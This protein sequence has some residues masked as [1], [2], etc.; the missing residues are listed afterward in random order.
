MEDAATAEIARSQVWQWVVSPKGVL[1]DGRKVDGPLVK[2]LIPEE[3]VKVKKE[4]AA[5]GE[6]LGTYDQAAKIFE[7]MALSKTFQEFL[8]LPLYEAME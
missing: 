8:T 1:D 3:L 6:P 4:A 2:A 5:A 7:D